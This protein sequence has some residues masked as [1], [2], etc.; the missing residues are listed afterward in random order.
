[1]T[2]VSRTAVEAPADPKPA[3]SLDVHTVHTAAYL[4]KV[5]SRFAPV[6]P[7][8]KVTRP[9]AGFLDPAPARSLSFGHTE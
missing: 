5:G 7:S 9:V 4:F 2:A 8:L 3:F 1:M 6:L